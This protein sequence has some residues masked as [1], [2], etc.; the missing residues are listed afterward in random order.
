M[1]YAG[2]DCR[3][4]ARCYVKAMR[5]GVA[6]DPGCLSGREADLAGRFSSVESAGDCLVEPGGPT[7]SGM[8]SGAMDSQA[9]ALMLSGGKCAGAKM[10]GLGRECKQLLRCYT[11]SVYESSP[12]DPACLGK[13]S[14]KVLSTFS[15]AET[16]YAADCFTEGDASARD[17][18]ML[19][20]AD[21]LFSYL[22]GTGTTTTS[23]TV[24][25]TTT[26]PPPSCPEDG[27]I[28]P[29]IAYRDNPACTTCVDTAGGIA[30]SQCAAS[31][32]TCADAFLNQGCGYAINTATTCGPTCCP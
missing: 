5:R 31:G 1:K 13:S 3:G 20:L 15:R 14:S 17:A 29:C 21:G 6:A 9:N 7:V 24:S 10:G 28:T 4:L 11:D 19:T 8:V 16:R 23:T 18:D 2:T 32:P 25:S 30:Q 26:L 22:R 27:S 12:V